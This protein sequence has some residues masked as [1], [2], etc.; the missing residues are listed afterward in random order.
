[1]N[2]IIITLYQRESEP[3]FQTLYKGRYAWKKVHPLHV[4]LSISSEE[5]MDAHQEENIA[6]KRHVKCIEALSINHGSQA[7]AAISL[8]RVKQ[9]SC[10]FCSTSTHSNKNCSN[11]SHVD[12]IQHIVSTVRFKTRSQ[13]IALRLPIN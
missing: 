12:R 7:E 4:S 5:S 2:F 11:N 10:N 3:V 13:A 9:R 1:M 6:E 8:F